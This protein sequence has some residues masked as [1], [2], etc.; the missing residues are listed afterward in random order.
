[1]R[2]LRKLRQRLRLLSLEAQQAIIKEVL[3]VLPGTTFVDES[4]K[5]MRL[6]VCEGCEIMDKDTRKCNDCGCFIDEKT[7]VLS[8]PFLEAEKCPQKKW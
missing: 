8:L 2:R 3:D 1:M 4:V 5:E 7:R 6:K